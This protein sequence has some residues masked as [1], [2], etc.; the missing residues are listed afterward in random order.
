MVFFGLCLEHDKA[1]S[2]RNMDYKGKIQKINN[3]FERFENDE[4]VCYAYSWN[5]AKGGLS[6]HFK[7]AEV[8]I[9]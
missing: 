6:C 9:R 4:V 3:M 5:R 2:K 1:V 7:G 8:T